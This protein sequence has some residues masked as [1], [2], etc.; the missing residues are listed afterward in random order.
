MP[1]VRVAPGHRESVFAMNRLIALVACAL[2]A[3]VSAVASSLPANQISA[4]AKWIL[5]LDVERFLRGKI[6]AHLIE[7]VVEK[8]A[9]AAKQQLKNDLGFDLDW[10]K[11]L[12]LTAYGS[13]YQPDRDTSAVILLRTRLDLKSAL[14]AAMTREIPGLEVRK[15]G[16]TARPLYSLNDNAFAAFESSELVLVSQHRDAIDK[17]R[18]VLSGARPNLTGAAAVSGYPDT[19]AGFFLI[20]LADGFGQQA[21]LP[22][23]AAILRQALGAQVVLGEVGDRLRL[24][25]NLKTAS[26]DSARQIQM[27][28]QGLLALATLNAEQN[29]DLKK[30]TQAASINVAGPI[31]TLG[32]ELPIAD[33]I[34]RLRP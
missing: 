34:Q 16:D 11:I 32:A 1:A 19:P 21:D 25:L 26:A 13:G 4:D 2:C 20:A 30:L 28:A 3:A 33:V 9:A 24:D 27:V 6:G 31:L 10:S 8:Q 12:S 18:A 23:T 29:P 22:P 15:S 17:A 14:D 5:H 7:N